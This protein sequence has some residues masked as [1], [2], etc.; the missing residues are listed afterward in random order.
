MELYFI[1]IKSSPICSLKDAKSQINEILLNS[2]YNST[3]E[4]IDK[5]WFKSNF[6]Y[7]KYE[8]GNFDKIKNF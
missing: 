4:P 3:E 2:N 6:R 7:S 5:F 1:L 8:D